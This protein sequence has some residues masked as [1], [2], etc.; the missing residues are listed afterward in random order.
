MAPVIVR[1]EKGTVRLVIGAQGGPRITSSVA[2]VLLNRFGFGFSL[3]DSVTAARIHEQ[4]KP[5]ILKYETPGL[6]EDTAAKLRALG[7]T[8]APERYDVARVHAIERFTNGRVWGVAD[9]RG[10]GKAV[11]E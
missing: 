7:Y 6:S 5:A 10:E 4:W 9:P 8:I 2:Q 1:G 11:A 3:P